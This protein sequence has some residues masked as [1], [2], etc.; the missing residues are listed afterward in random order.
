MRECDRKEQR[1]R[2]GLKRFPRVF[3]GFA[4]I[5]GSLP[6]LSNSVWCQGIFHYIGQ[7]V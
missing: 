5:T 6:F 3:G 4:A 1:D 7:T 2:L